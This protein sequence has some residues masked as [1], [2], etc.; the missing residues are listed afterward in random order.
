MNSQIAVA[1]PLRQR[2]SRV[3]FGLVRRSGWAVRRLAC[4]VRT[5]HRPDQ[6]FYCEPDCCGASL[7]WHECRCGTWFIS[8]PD[9]KQYHVSQFFT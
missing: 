1:R 3:L 9:G 8:A 6:P 5:G 4:R 2:A 7:L